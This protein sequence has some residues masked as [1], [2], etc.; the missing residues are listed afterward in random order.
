MDFILDYKWFFL[1]T[2]E[3]VFWVCA[4]AFLLLRY[5]FKLKKL[6]L[7]VFV[8]F[9]LNDLW[10]ALLAYLDYQRTGE[11]SIYQIII[12]IIIVY[13]M[14]FGKSDFKKLDAFI[15]RWVAKKRGEPIDESLQP[16]K[17]YGKAYALH[18]W[19]Q[20]AG[21]FVVFIIVHIGFAIAVGFSDSLQQMALNDF[22][23][24]WFDDDNSNFPFKNEGIN[25]F[26]QV[27]LLILAIDFV[28]TL[29]YTLFPKKKS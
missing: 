23:G 8:I 19:K 12:V 25:K 1:I 22:F 29:S 24:M 10:I 5:W 15:K 28:I 17:L 16:V 2:A 27:W 14:T 20:F 13:A 21:H 9:I 26:S 6:S 7:F 11:F 3:V 18:E 4:I